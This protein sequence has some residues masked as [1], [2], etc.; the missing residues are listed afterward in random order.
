MSVSHDKLSETPPD[1][2]G[3]S[4]QWFVRKPDGSVYGPETA[5]PTA[6]ADRYLAHVRDETYRSSCIYHAEGGCSLPRDMKAEVCGRYWCD[7]LIDFR[8]GL[9]DGAPRRAYGLAVREGAVVREAPLGAPD[10][11]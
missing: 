3:A 4:V 7:G 10:V 11:P 6:V 2:S 1:D 8:K 5:E 9:P